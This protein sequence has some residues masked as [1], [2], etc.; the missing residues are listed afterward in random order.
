MQ[1]NTTVTNVS[2]LIQYIPRSS[3]H[4]AFSNDP[5]LDTYTTRSYHA[6]NATDGQGL[7]SFS[8]NGTGVWLYGGYR[9]R[10]GPYEV[11][12]DDQSTRFEGFKPGDLETGHRL[13]YGQGGLSGSALHTVQLRVIEGVLDFDYL[14]FETTS[15]DALSTIYL[16][17]SDQ[18][19]T[20]I[21]S[22][23]TSSKFTAIERVQ[24]N[25][26]GEA[27]VS[28]LLYPWSSQSQ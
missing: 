12:L 18:N 3:W 1:F 6:T 5:L 11:T 21:H 23:S 9:E 28:L 14:Q 10:L 24:L 15:N 26:S 17:G 4:E 2:P 13:L 25:Y 16:D 20:Y 8:W 19:F 22:N 27:Y 7:L